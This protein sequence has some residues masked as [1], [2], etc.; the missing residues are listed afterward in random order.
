[1][2]YAN[3]A[4]KALSVSR[5]D[6]G[7]IL[8]LGRAK[9]P[10]FW[11]ARNALYF[12][13][14]LASDPRVMLVKY[15][16]LVSQPARFAEIFRH[17]GIPFDPRSIEEVHASSVGRRPFGPIREDVQEVCDAMMRRLETAALEQSSAS[18]ATKPD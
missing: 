4:S 10:I 11:Y 13:M 8:P 12:E 6:R 18:Q 2:R 7:A 15:D 1:M 14:D 16:E 3:P 17:V 5:K 9:Q